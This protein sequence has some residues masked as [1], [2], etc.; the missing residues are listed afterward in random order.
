MFTMEERRGSRVHKL[1]S[2]LDCLR[3]NCE[4]VYHDCM[5]VALR[6]MGDEATNNH[7]DEDPSGD[8]C[9]RPLWRGT[10][11]LAAELSG[12]LPEIPV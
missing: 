12:R 3:A 10:S 2:S 5:L 4:L 1:L 7:G 8:I 6:V 11:T 9:S